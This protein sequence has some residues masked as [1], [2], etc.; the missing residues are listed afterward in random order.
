MDAESFRKFTTATDAIS[1]TLNNTGRTNTRKYAL[2]NCPVEVKIKIVFTKPNVEITSGRESILLNQDEWTSFVGYLPS[3]ER[4]I[5][6][7]TTNELWM[8]EHVD[9]VMKSNKVYVPPPQQLNGY[10][11]DRLQ[12]EVI[13]Y[14]MMQHSMD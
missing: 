5:D 11:A 3:I 13:N 4:Y 14:K 10:E 2:V 9:R 8:V 6:H 1:F 12:D 7:L